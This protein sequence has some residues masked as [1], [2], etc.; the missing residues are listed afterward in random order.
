MLTQ[1]LAYAD[2]IN[3]LLR[4]VLGAKETFLKPDNAVKEVAL[5]INEQ[6]A[7]IMN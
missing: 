6:E 4:S 2:Y 3:I 7:K 5:R 1:V